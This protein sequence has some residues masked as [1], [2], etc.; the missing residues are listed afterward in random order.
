MAIDNDDIEHVCS[1][2][3]HTFQKA[4]QS[5]T[6]HGHG[7]DTHCQLVTFTLRIFRT[8]HY[9]CTYMYVH[10]IIV[11]TYIYEPQYFAIRDKKELYN[12]L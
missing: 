1:P 2:A 4:I 7:H 8:Q 11:S 3:T 6:K 12:P 10:I 9:P 5:W